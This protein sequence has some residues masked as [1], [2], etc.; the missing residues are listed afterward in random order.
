MLNSMEMGVALEFFR[1]TSP[2]RLPK[3]HVLTNWS[4][5]NGILL[6][7]DGNFRRRGL[8]GGSRSLGAYPKRE[9]LSYPC[10]F[11]TFPL[12]VLAMG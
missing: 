6:R 2:V 9:N 1:L 12:Q 4:L 5:A 7:D 8:A 11:L 3:T 10:L